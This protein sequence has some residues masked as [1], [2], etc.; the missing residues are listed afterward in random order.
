MEC[1][2]LLR[3][4]FN[5]E[6]LEKSLNNLIIAGACGQE[7]GRGG[8]YYAVKIIEIIRAKDELGKLWAYL[9]G[10]IA[11]IGVRGREVLEFYGTCRVG[12]KSLSDEVRKEIKKYTARFTRRLRSLER[13]KE[14]LSLLKKYYALT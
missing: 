1:K 6:K 3:F 13:F 7:F 5:A 10:V 12:F 2:R 4:Y 14:G 11:Q 8:E 9:D